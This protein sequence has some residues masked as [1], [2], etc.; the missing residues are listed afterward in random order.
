MCSSLTVESTHDECHPMYSN[1]NSL[2]R[3]HGLQLAI[4][5]KNICSSIGRPTLANQVSQQSTTGNGHAGIHKPNHIS[6]LCMDQ[7]LRPKKTR[8]LWRVIYTHMS[9]KKNSS[10][11]NSIHQILETKKHKQPPKKTHRPGWKEKKLHQPC[12]H[13]PV[14]QSYPPRCWENWNLTTLPSERVNM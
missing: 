1:N 10:T 9:P 5:K 13:A 4:S 3:N 7:K 6:M 12:N 8:I 14:P 2:T 11:Q